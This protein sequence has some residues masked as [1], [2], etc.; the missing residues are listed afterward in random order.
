MRS[1]QDAVEVARNRQVLQAFLVAHRTA[2]THAVDNDAMLGPM[3]GLLHHINSI[4]EVSGTCEFFLSGTVC[5]VGGVITA[6]EL[7][8]LQ[9]VRDVSEEMRH[10][11]IGGF[12]V[13]ARIGIDT[14]R[15]IMAS[16]TQGRPDGGTSGYE[17]VRAR[18][19]EQMLGQIRSAEVKNLVARDPIERA[20]Q[21]LAALIAIVEKTVA[22]ARAG[23]S[24]ERSQIMSQVLRELI[25][26]CASTPQVMLMTGLLRDERLDYLPRHLASST[27]MSVLVG[28]EMQLS[29]STLM[30]VAQVTLLHE[31]GV[32]VYGAHLESAG[33][34]LSS[35]DRQIVKE[36]PYLGARIFLRRNSFDEDALGAIL[37]VVESK[38]PFDEPLGLGGKNSDDTPPLTMLQARIVQTCA[39]FDALTSR[40][41][42]REAMTIPAALASIGKGQPRLDPSVTLALTTIIDDPA[43]LLN[44][45]L[46]RDDS[47]ASRALAVVRQP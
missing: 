36:L 26:S 5:I 31:V 44:R 27:I 10:R 8:Q 11:D 12:R 29:R 25:D 39:T 6:P 42:F 30:Q 33:R 28:L 40:R 20:L 34:E 47:S 14:A 46:S 15:E 41:P 37:A 43:R 9:L 22:D 17:M 2:R 19:V 45:S 3:Q 13:A 35:A 1:G 16:I 4:I 18:P 38:R 23:R 21:I 7:Q 24:P 32:A